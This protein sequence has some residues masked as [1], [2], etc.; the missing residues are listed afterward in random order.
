MAD[1]CIT[2]VRYNEAREHIV[3]VHVR[4]EKGGDNVGAPRT[5]SRHFI[6]D[7]I[8]LGKASFQTRTEGRNGNWIKGASV[9]VYDKKFLTTEGNRTQRDNLGELP[10]F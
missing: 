5:V 9:V 1:F 8:R 3:F 6:A 2:Q 4:E 10:E 7:L